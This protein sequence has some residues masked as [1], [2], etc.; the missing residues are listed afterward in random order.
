MWEGWD[1]DTIVRLTNGQIWE[2]RGSRLSIS[3]KFNP[4]VTIFKKGFAYYMLIEG[5]NKPVRVTRLN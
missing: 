2:Q 5:E 4:D 3:I 1:G